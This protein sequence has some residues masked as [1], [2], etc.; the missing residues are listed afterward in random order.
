MTTTDREKK[1]KMKLAERTPHRS[2]WTSEQIRAED[3]RPDDVLLLDGAWREVVGVW[4]EA[5]EAREDLGDC[6]LIEDVARAVARADGYSY[7]AV[8]LVDYETSTENG[9]EW[10]VRALLWCEL[11][12]VQ[13]KVPV[14]PPAPLASATPRSPAVQ[15]AVTARP[16][17]GG[18]K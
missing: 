13:K 5:E 16:A 15:L 18:M 8:A 2:S 4:S 1:I 17:F 10:E 12:T 3:L 6:P 11:V 7:R 14:E 9:A